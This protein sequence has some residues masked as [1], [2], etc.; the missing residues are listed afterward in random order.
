MGIPHPPTAA[1][2]QVGIQLIHFTLPVIGL[3]FTG[4]N[5]KALIG[6]DILTRC[7]LIYSG[8]RANFTLAF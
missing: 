3:D 5:I 1:N 4:Q 6:R 8:T 2:P 7:M